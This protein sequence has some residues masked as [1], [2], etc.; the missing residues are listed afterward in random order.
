LNT[1]T[2]EYELEIPSPIQYLFYAIAACWIQQPLCHNHN[3][4]LPPMS[5]PKILFVRV[6]YNVLKIQMFIVTENSIY[7]ENWISQHVYH[8]VLSRTSLT[9]N[10]DTKKFI[11]MDRL[12]GHCQNLEHEACYLSNN[13]NNAKLDTC[14]GQEQG[15]CI[16]IWPVMEIA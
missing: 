1:T 15:M 2:A 13:T 16:F 11:S 14:W 8:N 5:Q 10:E 3:N 9:C 4:G 12:S 6:W 7:N